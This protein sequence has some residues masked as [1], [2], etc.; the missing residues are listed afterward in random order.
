[1]K[2]I[3]IDDDKISRDI[4]ELF[5]SKHPKLEVVGHFENPLEAITFLKS[6]EVDLIF[7][8]VEMPEMTGIEF[9]NS[10]NESLPKVILTTSHS[11]FAVEA[12]KYNVSG[13]LLKPI[14]FDQFSLAVKKAEKKEPITN[15]VEFK[16][17][18][19]FIKEAKT[20]TKVDKSEI[21]L[22]EC[23]GDYVNLFSKD[24][25]FT[26]HSSMKAI[27]Q[28]FPNDE[29]L[30]VHRSFI[31]LIDAIEDIEDDTISFGSKMIPIGK[32]YKKSIY[33]RLNIL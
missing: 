13:Y 10:L 23:I 28:R 17:N 30:R 1:M 6:N 27:E 24:K 25:K 31:I 8:D 29:Y 3:I 2:C 22:I 26:V 19:I 11:E 33:K 21:K 12:F 32:T 20:I 5:I 7:L 4:L 16:E 18:I 14:Q 9:I 15:N